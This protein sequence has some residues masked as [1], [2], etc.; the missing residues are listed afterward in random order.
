MQQNAG[1]DDFTLIWVDFFAS[2][3][4][5]TQE[6]NLFWCSLI[7]WHK[8]HQAFCC[9]CCCCRQWSSSTKL[10]VSIIIRNWISSWGQRLLGS[11]II[12]LSWK[13]TTYTKA[14]VWQVVYIYIIIYV[15]ANSTW[16]VIPHLVIKLCLCFCQMERCALPLVKA[17]C[18]EISSSSIM[19]QKPAAT[20]V[21]NKAERGGRF[22]LTS[23]PHS[24]TIALLELCTWSEYTRFYLL[25]Q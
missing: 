10:I 18:T 17:D 11:Q 20:S 1:V 21:L 9:C 5:N 23:S 19:L 8:Q 2:V 14:L 13:W 6:R 25:R 15:Y 24:L 3:V 7:N 12:D 4:P 16:K 22:T